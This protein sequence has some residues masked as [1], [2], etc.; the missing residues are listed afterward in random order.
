[1]P[2]T[3]PAI[4]TAGCKRIVASLKERNIHGYGGK[5]GSPTRRSAD[6]TA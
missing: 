1:V 2:D 4:I 3:I 5:S 6:G